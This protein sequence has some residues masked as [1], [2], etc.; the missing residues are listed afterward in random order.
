M[1]H[2]VR[3]EDSVTFHWSFVT[4][5]KHAQMKP[6][7][8][9]Q[10]YRTYKNWPATKRCFIAIAFQFHFKKYQEGSQSKTGGAE[11]EQRTHQLLA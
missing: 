3:E 4:S 2:S 9:S 11:V 6:V 10:S 8:N 1:Y 7:I 5:P